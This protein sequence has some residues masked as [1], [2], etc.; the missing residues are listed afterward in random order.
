MNYFQSFWFL[1][2]FVI[3]IDVDVLFDFLEKKKNHYI[4]F[5]ACVSNTFYIFSLRLDL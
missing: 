5:F 1:Q 3:I 4:V 2:I